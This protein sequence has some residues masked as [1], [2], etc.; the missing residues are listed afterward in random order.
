MKLD[1]GEAPPSSFSPASAGL[2]H[3]TPLGLKSPVGVELD[4]KL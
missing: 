1:A 2:I 4:S 3:R